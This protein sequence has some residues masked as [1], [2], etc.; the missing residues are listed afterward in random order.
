VRVLGIDPGT[1]NSA[2]VLYDSEHPERPCLAYGWEPNEDLLEKL[3]GWYSGGQALAGAVTS[4]MAPPRVGIEMVAHYGTGMSVGKEVFETCIWI[5]RFQE[6]IEV[7]RSG[8]VC[9]IHKKWVCSHLCRDTRA[10]SKH[11]AQALRDLLGP[12]TIS[13]EVIGPKGGVK[14]VTEPGPTHGMTEHKWSALSI[15]VTLVHADREEVTQY[16]A[17]MDREEAHSGS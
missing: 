5:G 16:R 15:A 17:K 9:L 1:T 6:A 14:K 11:I 3:R 13:R 12:T 10:K 8:S 2:W 7:T 4:Y